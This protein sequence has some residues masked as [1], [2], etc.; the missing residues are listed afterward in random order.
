MSGREVVAAQWR[1]QLL[2]MGKP[3]WGL[4]LKGGMAATDELHDL[5]DNVVVQIMG[6]V[7]SVIVAF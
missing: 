4:N 7:A 5:P 6:F 2:W 3:R 1:F